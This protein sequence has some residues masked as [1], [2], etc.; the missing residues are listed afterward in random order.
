MIVGSQKHMRIA[1][2]VGEYPTVSHSFILREVAALRNHG[3]DV[4]TCSVRTTSADQH[5]GPEEREEAART[6]NL[7]GAAK[8]PGTM[9]GA[10][11]A[12][13]KKPGLYFRTLARSWKM[14]GPGW[15]S[16]LYQLIYFTEAVVLAEHLKAQRVT[17]LH[18][19]FAHASCTVALLAARLA[20]IPFS[21]TLHGPV[22]FVNPILWRLD[23]KIA[24]A[25]FVACISHYCRS[26]A[27][28][29]S[30]SKHWN[31]LHII[32]CGVEPSR[33]DQ[34]TNNGKEILFIGRLAAEKGAPVL[35]DA[36]PRIRA[37]H[38]DLQLT[39]IGD[40]P[41]REQLETQVRD[42]ALTDVVTFTGYKNQDEV[43][44]ALGGTALFVLPSFAE[45][46]PVVLMEAMAARTPVVTTRIAGIPELVE[47]GVS[48]RIVPPGDGEALADA[49][50]EI[51]NSPE[52]ARSMGAKGREKV[53]AEFDVV[54]EARKL[55]SLFEG[56][57]NS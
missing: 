25:D 13:L 33:Y 37:T 51:L 47:D 17:H 4:M 24:D 23:T 55:A 8:N 45:G 28:L 49:I 39:L 43:A 10:Q 16:A 50:I 36:L 27:M 40:G 14:R 34:E 22:D 56:S 18:S 32:H 57:A 54:K 7:L 29:V 5:R 38:P 26:Q 6:F 21:F 1:Y 2:L 42:L 35:I 52:T 3:L 15:R 44:E 30:P 48:G 41:E 20:E 12:A 46:V 53:E 9:I 31:K 11:I 19:H